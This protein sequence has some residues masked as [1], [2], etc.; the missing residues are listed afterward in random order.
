MFQKF[1][2]RLEEILGVEYIPKDQKWKSK[3]RFHELV[4]SA[5]KEIVIVA[6]E[7]APKFY[8]DKFPDIIA[9]KIEHNSEFKVYLLFSK[10]AEKKEDA[11]VKIETENPRIVS[12]L[13]KYPNNIT[14]YWANR[15]PQFHFD[16]CDDSLRLEKPHEVGNQKPVVVVRNNKNWADTYRGYFQNMLMKQDVVT[17]LAPVDFSN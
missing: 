14:M 8:D 11:I 6:G 9:Q 1:E 2:R 15:R 12:V 17:E 7:L 10:V 4:K 3:E 13:K 5:Q 16:I